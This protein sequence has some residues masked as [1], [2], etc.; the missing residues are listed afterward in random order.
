MRRG[1]VTFWAWTVSVGVHLAILTALG[2]AKFPWSKP[3]SRQQPVPIARVSRVKELMQAAA[4]IPKPKI[5][6]PTV[7]QFDGTSVAKSSLVC[8]L[9]GIKPGAESLGDLVRTQGPQ[10]V[11]PLASNKLLPE[12]IEFFGSSA[13]GRKVCYIVDCSGSMAGAFGR[14]RKE[15]KKSVRKLQQDQY[16]DI[17]FFGAGKVLE[18]GGGRMLRASDPSKFAAYGFI[19]SV[20]PSGQT[21]AIASLERAVQIHDAAGLGPSVVYFLTDGF[22]LTEQ[23]T[24]KTSEKITNLLKRFASGTRINTIGFWPQSN[25]RKML[26]AIASVSGGEF[27]LVTDSRR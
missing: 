14:V 17:I 16:F 15:L 6:K 7:Q 24:Q 27:V 4:I 19:D 26:Q 23:D 12:R 3:E 10:G 25:D 21:N 18:F 11:F 2:F 13:G 20:R 5:S 22:E 9:D 8:T 1:S